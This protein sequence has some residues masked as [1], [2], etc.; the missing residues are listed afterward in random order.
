MLIGVGVVGTFLQSRVI[1]ERLAMEFL[2][3]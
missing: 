2:P 1:A 3:D